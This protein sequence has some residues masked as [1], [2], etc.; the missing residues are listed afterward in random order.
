MSTT[1]TPS[2]FLYCQNPNQGGFDCICS[3]TAMK[4]FLKNFDSNLSDFITSTPGGTNMNYLLRYPSLNPGLYT[5]YFLNK[6]LPGQDPFLSVCPWWQP[7][8]CE[9]GNGSITIGKPLVLIPIENT[10]IMQLKTYIN[11]WNTYINNNCSL[12][13]STPSLSTPPG[14]MGT[15]PAA[16]MEGMGDMGMGT[17]PAGGMGG[18]PPAG[19]MRGTP[20]AGGMGGTPPAGGMGMGTPPAGTGMGGGGGMGGAGMGGG[21]MGTPPVVKE[22]YYLSQNFNEPKSNRLTMAYAYG[23]I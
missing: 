16:G 11:A 19:G 12:S 3:S 15:P 20:P 13:S 10:D 2:A 17:P 1:P 8:E 9:C 21:G 23:G 6:T 22:K 14:M 7:C 18:T 4:V 5:L